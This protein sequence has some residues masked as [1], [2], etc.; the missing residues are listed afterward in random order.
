MID[1]DAE[2]RVLQSLTSIATGSHRLRYALEARLDAD[3]AFRRFVR[4]LLDVAERALAAQKADH[5]SERLRPAS[6]K[7][8]I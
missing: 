6:A 2:T 8:I 7:I 4:G 5:D 3:A 1:P